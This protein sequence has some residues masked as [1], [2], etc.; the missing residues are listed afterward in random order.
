VTADL[1]H[2]D[3]VVRPA[4]PDDTDRVAAVW[5]QGWQEVHPGEV[6]AA[7]VAARTTASFR[8]RAGDRVPDTL[9]VEVGGVV[10]GFVMTDADEV[11]Q[12]YVAPVGRGSG[13]AIALLAAAEERIRSAGHS[14]AWL[15]VVRGNA[16]AR[17][18]YERQGWADQGEFTHD[19]PGPAGPISVTAHRYVKHLGAPAD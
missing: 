8:R 13:A 4:R 14:A 6:P 10:V 2:L 3:G 17:A 11:D 16:R 12:V 5:E 9:V 15:A 7:L 19:A 1:G 18:F